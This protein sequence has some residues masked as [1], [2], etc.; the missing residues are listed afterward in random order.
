M[1]GL[2]AR[3]FVPFLEE[4]KALLASSALEA[5]N[6]KLKSG[7][8]LPC[9]RFTRRDATRRECFLLVHKSQPVT[10]LAQHVCFFRWPVCVK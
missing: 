5:R 2:R 8:D 9:S 10:L 7:L 1:V 6:D 3:V 4:R